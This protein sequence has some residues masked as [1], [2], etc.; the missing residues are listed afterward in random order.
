MPNITHY[1]TLSAPY[2]DELDEKVQTAINAGWQPYG[3]Q[4]FRVAFHQ[5]MVKYEEA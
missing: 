5:P 2:P 1:K 4:F 3:P